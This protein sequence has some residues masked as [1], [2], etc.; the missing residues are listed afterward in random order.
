MAR[1]ILITAP[2]NF[3]PGVIL[4]TAY[5]EGQLIQNLILQGFTL[6][7]LPDATLEAASPVALKLGNKFGRS[8]AQ[9]IMLAAYTQVAGG[10]AGAALAAAVAA[11]ATAD[12]A[13]ATADAASDPYAYIYRTAHSLVGAVGNNDTLLVT[14]PPFLSLRS[15]EIFVEEAPTGGTVDLSLGSTSGASEIIAITACGATGTLIGNQAAHLGSAWGTD[16]SLYFQNATGF[17]VR[18]TVAG[19]PVTAGSIRLEALG[20]LKA[21]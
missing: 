9:D 15:V 7:S 13:Q 14:F 19:A 2:F 8:A 1:Y 16:L 12:A 4:D 10:S 3:V 18:S 5:G 17:Y 20:V 21:L 6:I 11:Q